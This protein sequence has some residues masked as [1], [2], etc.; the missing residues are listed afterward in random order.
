MWLLLSVG[1][2]GGGLEPCC[3]TERIKRAF[4]VTCGVASGHGSQRNK[5]ANSCEIRCHEQNL[6]REQVESMHQV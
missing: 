3:V 6:H 5:R 1:V 4:D 2:V